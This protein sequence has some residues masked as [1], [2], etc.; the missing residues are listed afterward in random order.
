MHR[1]QLEFRDS[2]GAGLRT[3]LCPASGPLH[4]CRLPPVTR[5]PIS[6]GKKPAASKSSTTELWSSPE[7][8]STRRPP[9]RVG[10]A[11]N[12]FRRKRVGRL[13]ETGVDNKLGYDLTRR[14]PT[15]RHEL[16]TRKMHGVGRIDDNLGPTKTTVP[17]AH[18]RC[19][20]MEQ[21]APP[22]N[23]APS[24]LGTSTSP[25]QGDRTPSRAW[26]PQS[27]RS[28]PS[29]CRFIVYLG[30]RTGRCVRIAASQLTRTVQ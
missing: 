9:A 25:T 14:Q 29:S 13:P 4:C 16:E 27:R 23:S 26:P 18:R 17:R 22:P 11:P 2:Q 3:S 1:R 8:N 24:R 21:R 5:S 30:A 12:T 19:R 10:S 6:I 28:V 7:T 20:S 15:E